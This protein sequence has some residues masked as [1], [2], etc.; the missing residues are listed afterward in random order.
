MNVKSAFL[1]SVIV[2]KEV[3]NVIHFFVDVVRRIN[4]GNINL[5]FTKFAGIYKFY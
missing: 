2:I 1:K 4:F 5:V 3:E